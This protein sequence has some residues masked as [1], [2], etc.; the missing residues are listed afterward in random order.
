MTKQRNYLCLR[1]KHVFVASRGAKV[2]E[3]HCRIKSTSKNIDIDLAIN[4]QRLCCCGSLMD[5]VGY[6]KNS[7]KN[8]QIHDLVKMKCNTKGCHVSRA[9]NTQG[10]NSMLYKDLRY[11]FDEFDICGQDCHICGSKKW[12]QEMGDLYQVIFVPGDKK[13]NKKV[14]NKTADDDGDLYIPEE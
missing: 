14:E 6:E 9:Q 7:D 11:G 2:T 5:I 12:I 1:C 3:H 4:C 10:K 13:T 8:T